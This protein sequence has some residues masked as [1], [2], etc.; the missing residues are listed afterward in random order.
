M[1]GLPGRCEKSDD[2]SPFDTIH[3]RDR[4]MDTERRL[5]YRAYGAAARL[6][7]ASCGKNQWWYCVAA[8]LLVVQWWRQQAWRPTGQVHR[9]CLSTTRWP[10][11]T[12]AIGLGSRTPHHPIVSMAAF[13]T[14]SPTTLPP[15]PVMS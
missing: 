4:Q 10:P 7:A 2:E 9:R 1:I 11:V 14:A 13:T 8:V 12:A 3:E 6:L 5:K 15:L